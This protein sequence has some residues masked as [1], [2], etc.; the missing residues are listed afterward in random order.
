MGV[1]RILDHFGMYPISSVN[2]N[3]ISGHNSIENPSGPLNTVLCSRGFWVWRY[4][5]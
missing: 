5:S 4:L 3:E 2:L 1:M